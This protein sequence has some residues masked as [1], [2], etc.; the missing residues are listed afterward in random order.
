LQI[1][2][3]KIEEKTTPENS[4]I[5]NEVYPLKK[6]IILS[7]GSRNTFVFQGCRKKPIEEKL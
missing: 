2:K 5:W 3:T 1:T 7:Q 4:E 6:K